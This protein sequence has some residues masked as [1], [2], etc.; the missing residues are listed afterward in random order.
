LCRRVYVATRRA[1]NRACG[2]GYLTD[3]LRDHVTFSLA[4]VR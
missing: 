2:T 3:P 4:L 1:D